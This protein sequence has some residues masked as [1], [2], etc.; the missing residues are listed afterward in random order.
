MD[1]EVIENQFN[2]DVSEFEDD[3]GGDDIDDV[4]YR[5]QGRNRQSDNSAESSFDSEVPK[6]KTKNSLDLYALDQLYRFPAPV[7]ELMVHSI[8]RRLE[9]FK[10]GAEGQDATEK[11]L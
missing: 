10:T 2:L 4:D 11:N 8:C 9:K 1:D 5:P 3:D 6:Q 7:Q